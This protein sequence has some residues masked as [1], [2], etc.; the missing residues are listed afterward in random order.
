M[1]KVYLIMTLVCMIMVS[2]KPDGG[3]G[4]LKVTYTLI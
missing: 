3:D 1:K 4:R 2:C